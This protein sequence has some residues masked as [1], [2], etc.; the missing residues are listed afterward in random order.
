M[1]LRE[2]QAQSCIF[3]QKAQLTCLD[4]ASALILMRGHLAALWLRFETAD[5]FQTRDDPTY[6]CC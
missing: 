5:V 3:L 1:T 2:L 6:R 4:T